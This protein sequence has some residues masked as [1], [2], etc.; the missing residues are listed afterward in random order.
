MHKYKY[1]IIFIV[2]L[3]FSAIG[4]QTYRVI[5]SEKP[6]SLYEWKN[7]RNFG[8]QKACTMEAKLCLDGSYVSRTGPNCEFAACPNSEEDKSVYLEN[9]DV[10]FINDKGEKITI[11]ESVND[12]KDPINNK[13]YESAVLSPNKKFIA[14]EGTGWEW[15]ILEIYDIFIGKI[16]STNENGSAKWLPDSRLYVEGGC[17]M[18]LSCGIF[19]SIN[20][21]EPWKLIKTGE[22]HL[23][24]E[25]DSDC[26]CGTKLDTGECFFGNKNYINTLNQ[27]PDF[28]TGIDGKFVLKCVNNFCSQIRQ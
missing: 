4:W 16:Y 15:S 21:S 2:M 18:G 11:V 25:F 3:I 6:L 12:F 9:G 5:F 13:R 28:C 19:E 27:C 8:Q 24:C 17:G 20:N 10:Y 1:I 14:L 7:W 26:V 22:F 23:F